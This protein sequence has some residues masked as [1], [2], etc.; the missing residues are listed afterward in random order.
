LLE[1]KLEG[2][3]SAY[4]VGSGP[5]PIVENADTLLSRKNE[6]IWC[7]HNEYSI[8]NE[9]LSLQALTDY[10]G[11]D[12]D[13][14]LHRTFGALVYGEGLVNSSPEALTTEKAVR[15]F[16]VNVVV[17]TLPSGTIAEW[18]TGIRKL[19]EPL[20]PASLKKRKAGHERFWNDLWNKHY[21][22]V[23]SLTDSLKMAGVTNGYLLQR[24]INVCAGRGNMP[25]KFNGTIFNVDSVSEK[26]SFDADYRSWGG[27]YWFQNTRL[28]YWSMIHAGDFEM[29]RPLF[30]MYMDAL[31]MARYCTKKYYGHE[32]AYFPEVMCFWGTYNNDNYGWKRDG[33]PEGLIDNK[34]IRYHWEGGIELVA[35]MLD[36]YD[37][38][39]NES[40]LRDTLLPFASEI[41]MFNR[42]HYSKGPDGKVLFEPAQ[43]LETYWNISNPLPEIAGLRFIL[44]RLLR[45]KNL[46]AAFA[47][48]CRTLLADMPDMPVGEKDGQ[49]VL[50]PGLKLHGRDNEENPE[51]YAIFPFRHYGID[52]PSLELAV[53]TFDKRLA[54]AIFGWQQTGIQAAL[55]GKTEEAAAIVTKNFNTK[56]EGSRFPAFWGPNYD[57]VPGQD[58]GGVNERALQNMLIQTEDDDIILFPAWPTEWNVKFKLWAPK[59]TSIE[60]VLENGKLRSLKVVPE[61][62]IK[63]IRILNEHIKK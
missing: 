63:D 46:D 7:H 29:M 58:H 5:R 54:K 51:L 2:F 49:K 4:G 38:T 22:V 41:V 25:I 1:Q 56:H 3:F 26:Y 42:R 43:A 60:G 16:L 35:M 34:F 15:R 24:Y 52:K 57:W 14:L 55:L 23:G 30:R 10:P 21:I 11:A 62:R 47:E 12:K 39:L 40:F 61:K 9:T 19:A 31:P 28:P 17:S 53:T 36:Y 50:L 44:P 8:W 32:G 20:T 37:F 33:M 45:L 18:E 6:L 48:T 59:Q 27:C 13:P